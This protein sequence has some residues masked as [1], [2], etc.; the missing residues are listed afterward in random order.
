[1]TTKNPIPA[2]G[3]IEI[4]LPKW[5]DQ[6][7]ESQK[8]SYIN[9]Q[10]GIP[11]CAIKQ[12]M[13]QIDCSLIRS[14]T[15][16]TIV[17]KNMFTAERIAGDKFTFI[18]NNI[19]NPLSTSPVSLTLTTYAGILFESDSQINF[20]GVIDTGD[21]K[22][23]ATLPAAIDPASSIIQADDSTVSE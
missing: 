3:G 8:I 16:D 20:T 1:M 19:L 7:P 21:A 14:P 17:V 10:E 2:G 6:A 23:Q 5:N 15:Y 12:G 4:R 18:V 11:L 13:T 22:F 9:P